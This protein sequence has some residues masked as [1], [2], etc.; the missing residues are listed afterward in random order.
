LEAGTFIPKTTTAKSNRGRAVSASTET[1]AQILAR[2]RDPLIHDWL[3]LVERQDDLMAI[4]LTHE[5]R[6][7]HLPQLV[8]DVIAAAHGSLG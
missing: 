1:V 2:E 6:T 4:P 3:A 5:D 7:G 8:A